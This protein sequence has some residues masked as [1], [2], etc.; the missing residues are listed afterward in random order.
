MGHHLCGHPQQGDWPTGV[1]PTGLWVRV[2]CLVGEVQ[3]VPV[4]SFF[5][6]AF[7]FPLLF[8]LTLFLVF[9]FSFLLFPSCVLYFISLLLVFCCL[10][11]IISLLSF[12]FLNLF[13]FAFSPFHHPKAV[14]PELA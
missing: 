6:S 13:P 7:H 1:Q 11:F 4:F 14:G 8:F 5:S 2:R 10:S 12:T 3:G 9:L